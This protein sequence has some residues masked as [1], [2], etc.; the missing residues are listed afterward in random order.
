MET[1]GAS[2]PGGVGAEVRGTPLPW[3]AG[4]WGGCVLG[5]LTGRVGWAEVMKNSERQD[6][7]V[8]TRELLNFLQTF[9]AVTN[10]YNEQAS[11]VQSQK[12]IFAKKEANMGLA[13][14]KHRI[15]TGEV[16]CGENVKTI[17]RPAALVAGGTGG[18]RQ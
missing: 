2:G 10:F 7:E 13:G 15:R 1:R 16:R 18:I 17:P 4:S 11:H 5:T 8:G 3:A 14:A 6:K 12:E 9:C